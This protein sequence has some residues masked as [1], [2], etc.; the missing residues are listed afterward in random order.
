M[1]PNRAGSQ[2]P[3]LKLPVCPVPYAYGTFTYLVP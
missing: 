1:V 3:P 2:V